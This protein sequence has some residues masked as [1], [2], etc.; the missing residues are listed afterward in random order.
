MPDKTQISDRMKQY[1]HES[2]F[3]LKKK[4]PVIIRV[5]GKAFHTY[6]KQAK[7]PFDDS[8]MDA[9]NHCAIELLKQAQN[10]V[11]AYV[12]SDEISVLLLDDT[13]DTTESWFGNNIQKLAS[14]SASIVTVE[15]AQTLCGTANRALYRK[16][17]MF[18]ARCF[19]MPKE[20]VPNYFYWRMIDARRNSVNMVAQSIFGHKR[21]QNLGTRDRIELIEQEG[22]DFKEKYT[23]RQRLGGLYSSKS[24][25]IAD[26]LMIDDFNYDFIKGLYE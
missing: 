8:L 13:Q 26:N 12:Q 15:F 22:I 7:K 19:N 25:N 10:A 17:A 5:D 14:I 23:I 2:R 18:D 24:E 11:I 9:M 4:T 21:L 3:Y 1:E 16:H 6:T 20:D